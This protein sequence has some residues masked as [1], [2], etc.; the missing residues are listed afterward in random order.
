[1]SIF[2]RMKTPV[3][4]F[5]SF[6]FLMTAVCCIFFSISM[7]GRA[8][9]SQQADSTNEEM[10]E[11]T[12]EEGNEDMDDENGLKKQAVSFSKKIYH[13]HTGSSGSGGGCH[14]VKNT[15]T[16]TEKIKCSGKMVYWP[17]LDSTSCSKCGGSYS[18]DQSG[19]GCW[20]EDTKTVKYTYYTLG[21]NKS[22]STFLG[23]LTVTQDITDW[24]RSLHLTGSYSVEADLMKVSDKP[25]IWNG[26]DATDNAVYE[27]TESGD[28]TLQLN[29][30]SNANTIAGMVL[31]EVRNVDVTAPFVRA[32]T[33][34]PQSEWTKEGV[35]VTLTDVVDLQPDGSEGCGLH[36]QPYSYDNGETWTVENSHIYL[37]NGT[38]SIL[39]R[40]AL[41][42]T[43]S[44]D[45]TFYNV[46]C[47]PPAIHMID[48]DHT[49]NIRTLTIV[50][51]AEDIQPDGS[52]GCGLHE[53]PYSFDGGQ[54]WTA[55]KT[56]FVDKNGTISIAV[57]DKLENV[58]YL[59]ENITNI[60]CTGP[61]ISYKMKHHSWTNE[62]VKLYLSAKDINEDGSMGIGLPAAWYSLDGGKSWL[63]EEVTI[64][65]ENQKITVI[66]RDNHDNRST[67]HLKINQIDKDDPW[68]TL[69]ME[70]I[71][72][73]LD[74]RVMLTAEA[75]DEY[76]GLA[77][78]AYSW[79]K[80]ISYGT[81]NTKVVTENGTYQVTV[82]DK[83]G[84]WSYDTIEVDVFSVLL[85][86]P[87]IIE[88]KDVPEEE[89]PEETEI[90][91]ETETQTVIVEQ[92]ERIAPPDV[93][94]VG[95]L[96]QDD[97]DWNDTIA[98]I[99]SVLLLLGILVFLFL[100][101][102]RTIA[103][104]VEDM[105]GNMKYMG[106]QWIYYRERFEVKITTMLLEQCMTTHFSLR[107]SFLFVRL[108]REKDMCCL[109]PEDICII[110]QVER[111][112][113]IS[114][115]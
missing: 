86:I 87:I 41:E 47:T 107:P 98:L 83:A 56:L 45:V 75:G 15:G 24:T 82:R 109:F 8:E 61:E 110:K 81:D 76:S 105:N 66:A 104:Y 26:E 30:D 52:G 62:D 13:K 92:E 108:H 5:R 22:E 21:C 35:V 99:A 96:K 100:L 2:N 90:E 70:V 74:R 65:E 1:M 32:H 89:M 54:T 111:N 46:D 38:H 91:T 10:N 50:L 67:L 49:K 115:L 7:P 94:N 48:Y 102:L 27:V 63:G 77:D 79:D 43:S 73:G 64:Y 53:Q 95:S 71:G 23:S 36:E 101:W 103:I 78:K 9:E 51:T 40:D 3:H 57:R 60:D 84:N 72:D 19:R 39:V 14:S 34:E 58:Q 33:Q 6:I 114:L 93:Q 69:S 29:A 20:E 12:E 4:M 11:K 44:Y 16:R 37:E 68:V 106:R 42:N 28:Y 112:I 25:F 85:P 80:G 97:W 59:D 31:V 113:E 88:E 55:E 17:D 18:G